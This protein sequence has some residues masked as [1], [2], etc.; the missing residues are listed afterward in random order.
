MALVL[1]EEQ[2]LIQDTAREFC[3]ARAPVAQLRALRD[4]QDPT[5]YDP[6][7][8]QAMAELGWAGIAIPEAHGGTGFGW[9]ALGLILTETGRQLTAS[10]LLATVAIG[11]AAI[12]HGGTPEQCAALLPRIAAGELTLALALEEGPHHSP[13]GS[14]LAATPSGSGYR[15]SGRK[16]F[17]I[18]G[19]SAEQL[20]V[21]ARSSGTAGDRDGLTLL[22]VP[23][24]TPGITRTR[25]HMADSR[26]AA[27]VAFDDVQVPGD[28]VL[29]E[30]GAG[31][32]L[33]DR[34]LDHARIGL[35][36]EMLGSAEAAFERTV[37]Y[38]KERTQFGVPIG[39][40]Q[41]LKHRAADLFGELQLARS[42]VLDALAA[43]DDRPEEVPLLAS[44]AK[45]KVGAVLHTVSNEAVQ[46]HGGNGMTDE[47]DIG[48]YMKR[49]RVA[50]QAFGSAA[51]HRDR[52]AS[53]SGY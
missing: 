26:N 20:I 11:S 31:A 39:S 45:A 17:V 12:Q 28:A 22:L 36:A 4:A 1:D 25:T 27:I 15:L 40:F 35:A 41:A 21:V 24:S 29:G 52:Y 48:F 14:A 51:F 43:L 6:A 46:M 8:W 3:T 23:A 47:F 33:L 42:V 19:H 7:T 9:Q 30:P 34:M 18:D 2:S 13:Y 10:P 37:A 49:A 16:V 32:D 50:E 38:L 44:L 5:G 53:L